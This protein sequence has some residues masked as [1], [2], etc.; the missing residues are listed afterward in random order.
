MKKYIIFV[1]LI[2]VNTSAIVQ[3][4]DVKVFD[5]I[6]TNK[7]SKYISNQLAPQKAILGVWVRENSPSDKLEFLNNGV[8][9]TYE[10]NNL[11]YKEIYS[12]SNECDGNVSANPNDI[13][14]KT[15]DTD[16]GTVYCYFINGINKNIGD[17]LSLTDDSGK[18]LIYV[19]Q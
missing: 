12:I 4:N 9:N 15:I 14:L 18:I 8:L 7:D 16:D 17:F 19:K 6:K 3:S 10:D 11:L 13:F 1:L 2:I 5:K